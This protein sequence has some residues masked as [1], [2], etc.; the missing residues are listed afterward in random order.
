MNKTSA[1]IS[2][3]LVARIAHYAETAPENVDVD[4]DIATFRLDSLI[5]VNI[6][7]ELEEWLEMEVNPTLLWEMRTIAASAE[8]IVENQEA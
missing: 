6:T 5:M 7:A 2:E 3:W 8:W 4:S 1:E